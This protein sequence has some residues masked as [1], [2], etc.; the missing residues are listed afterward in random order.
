MAEKDETARAALRAYKNEW[1]R[2]KRRE[3]QTA[4][5]CEVCGGARGDASV[6]A[7]DAY[8]GMCLS[9]TEKVRR[10]EILRRETERAGI[11]SAAGP[12][13]GWRRKVSVRV[14]RHCRG[15]NLVASGPPFAREGKPGEQ[16]QR[17]LCLGCQGWSY[18]KP[19]PLPPD[20]LCPYC[21]GRCVRSG[22]LPSGSQ[23]YLCRNGPL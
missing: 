18:G 22:V 2:K 12:K 16:R 10:K 23:Q 9:C 15:R 8:K 5:V 20:L 4:G 3:R 17:F 11:G 13:G 19:L 1:Q 21:R 7:G 14:C 6:G